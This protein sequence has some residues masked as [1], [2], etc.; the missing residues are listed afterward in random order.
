MNIETAH[1]IYQS[2][3]KTSQTDLMEDMII[4]AIRYSHIRA[5]W[6]MSNRKVRLEMDAERTISHNVFIE[7]CNILGRE[8]GRKDEDNSWKSK[9]GEGR[10]TMGDF[11]CFIHLFK[12]IEA[13]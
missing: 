9:W 6:S 13:R 7:C 5:R 2:V 8:M 1:N 11:A 3:L 12:C 10:K 4:S